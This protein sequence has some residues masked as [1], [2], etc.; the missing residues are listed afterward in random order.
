MF[1]KVVNGSPP[2]LRGLLLVPHPQKA[3]E[4]GGG[5]LAEPGISPDPRSYSLTAGVLSPFTS[6]SSSHLSV[7][8]DV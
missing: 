3:E 6:S 1:G 2:S 4:A 8:D 5:M 7:R